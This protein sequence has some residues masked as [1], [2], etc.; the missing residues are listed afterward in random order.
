MIKLS[1]ASWSFH[2]LLQAG[3]QDMFK[4]ILDSK[5]LGA[6][7]L[8]PWNGH[9]A[10]LVVRDSEIKAAGVPSALLSADEFSY[11]A[12][13]KAAAQRVGLP[14]GCL[15]V[16]GAHIYEESPEARALNRAIAYRW[17]DAARFLECE[18]VRIDAGGP[19]AMPDDVF[20]VI[21]D[22]YR[23]LLARA[24]S[25][26]LE[27]LIENH[28]GPSNNPD[29]VVKLLDALPGLGL[30]FDTNNWIKLR[31]QE[32]WETCARYARS[33]HIKTFSFDENGNEPSV[34]IAKAI[35]ILQ[36]AGYKGTWG[37]ESVPQD[38][39]EYDGVK[40]SFALIRKILQA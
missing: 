9:L 15:A 3:R 7:Q 10:P 17:L 36:A 26:G 27:L 28:W 20:A 2:R 11:L 13:V 38:G 1:I 40:K 24:R 32:A 29:H 23:D 21:V 34:D 8:D 25:L 16:D 19:G 18:Q 6:T 5:A 37:V 14:F 4:Y 35:R 31:Q 12:Q 22:G 33:V 39:D 30:L